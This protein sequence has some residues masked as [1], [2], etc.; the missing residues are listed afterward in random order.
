MSKAKKN[1]P[2][3]IF[4]LDDTSFEEEAIK[5]DLQKV[6]FSNKDQEWLVRFFKR[7]DT[8]GDPSGASVFR[9]HFEDGLEIALRMIKEKIQIAQDR[10]TALVLLL[11]L[12]LD[13]G[14]GSNTWFLPNKNLNQSSDPSNHPEWI[15]EFQRYAK[16]CAQSLDRD[17]LGSVDIS[18]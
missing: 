4:P 5:Q 13:F 12:M 17:K 18:L 15:G 9:E 14:P 1:I 2:A 11:S 8:F 7:P 3:L 6:G 16:F 10:Q